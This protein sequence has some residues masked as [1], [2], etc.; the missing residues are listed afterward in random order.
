MFGNY[1]SDSFAHI[2][3]SPSWILRRLARG[4]C[5]TRWSATV[6]LY[7]TLKLRKKSLQLGSTAA[8]QGTNQLYLV[9]IGAIF[10]EHKVWVRIMLSWV[11]ASHEGSSVFLVIQLCILR[12]VQGSPNTALVR[13]CWKQGEPRKLRRSFCTFCLGALAFCFFSKF[14]WKDSSRTWDWITCHHMSSFLNRSQ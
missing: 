13:S 3:Q 7:I 12:M 10:W 1:K 2:C 14:L 5:C 6:K 4:Q 9:W 8:I 11:S